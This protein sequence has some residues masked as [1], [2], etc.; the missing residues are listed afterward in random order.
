MADPIQALAAELHIAPDLVRSALARCGL[1][2]AGGARAAAD[3]HLAA[4]QRLAG[5]ASEP[6]LRAA[7]GHP[8]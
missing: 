8:E 6:T 1:T 5:E 2:L 3:A 4:H 7:P